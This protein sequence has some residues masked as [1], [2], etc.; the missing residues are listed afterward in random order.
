MT[1][2]A[3]THALTVESL[4]DGLATRRIGRRIIVLPEVDSTNRYVLDVLAEGEDAAP[5]GTVVFAERQTAGR[6]RLG[7]SWHSPA[8]ASLLLTVL[9]RPPDRLRCVASLMMAATVAVVRGIE[10]STDVEPTIRWPN[11]LYVG[12]GKL[13]GILV[14]TRGLSGRGLA[15]AVGIG[16]NCLQH[17]GHFPEEIRSR[18]T[19]LELASSRA[20]DRPAVGR[21]ILRALDD[22]L[23]PSDGL[24]PEVLVEAWSQAS[25]DIGS[26]ATLV[27]DGA[28]FTGRILDVHPEEGLL[29][30]L[31][32]GAR[33]SFDPATTR[34][35]C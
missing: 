4:S 12:E 23:A 33:K 14:E 35:I 6:G 9:L 13:A 26:R 2:H 27:C 17:A 18:A 28:R 10:S 1:G 8:G 5:D 25:G 15:V 22:W 7:R 24:R 31:D 29:L 34:R 19:S 20:V 3:S 16:V 11:D 21:A 30:Q 32:T